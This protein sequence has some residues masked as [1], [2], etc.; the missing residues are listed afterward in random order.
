VLRQIVVT[1]K[2]VLQDRLYRVSRQRIVIW[3]PV[4]QDLGYFTTLGFEINV[5]CICM[6]TWFWLG[7]VKG[8]DHLEDPG[9]DGRAI[10]SGFSKT[11]RGG[12][13]WIVLRVGTSSGLL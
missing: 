7:N 4:L 13:G 10:L 5:Y 2:I 3:E 6:R 8:G 12:R 11:R 9:I 1:W